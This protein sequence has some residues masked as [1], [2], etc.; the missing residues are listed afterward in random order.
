MKEYKI[1]YTAGT[2]DLFHIGHLNLLAQAKEKCDYLIVGVNADELV[3]EYKG[4]K[5]NI[6][7]EDRARIVG[8]LKVV[9]EVHIM[10]SLDKVEAYKKYG[11]QAVFI[12]DDWKGNERWA[13]TEKELEPFGVKVE[14]LSHTDGI[15]TTLI[16]TKLLKGNKEDGK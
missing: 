2:F 7:A 6:C 13:R 10:H 1:G 4:K 5:T 16:A 15:S 12:G 9:D 3:Q 14:Y 8:A 11:F